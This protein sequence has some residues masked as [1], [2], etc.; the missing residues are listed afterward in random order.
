MAPAD[1]NRRNVSTVVPELTRVFRVRLRAARHLNI[2]I[3]VVCFDSVMYRF[4]AKDVTRT[5]RIEVG[6]DVAIN[7]ERLSFGSHDEAI[8]RE[9][10]VNA[11]GHDEIEHLFDCDAAVGRCAI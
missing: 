2:Y 11:V 9:I 6:G 5:F 7:A 3:L 8:V 1:R 4:Q 10:R